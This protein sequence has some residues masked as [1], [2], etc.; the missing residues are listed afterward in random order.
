MDRVN[1]TDAKAHLS[2]LVDRV[3]RGFDGSAL[4][5]RS[6]KCNVTVT[7]TVRSL[8]RIDAHCRGGSARLH[9]RRAT[10]CARARRVASAAQFRG[11]DPIDDLPL[12]AVAVCV[13]STLSAAWRSK[14]DDCEQRHDGK[15]VLVDHSTT[16]SSVGG[17]SQPKLPVAP[18]MSIRTRPGP[19]G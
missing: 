8:A 2:E 16:L 18:K 1:L 14:G 4:N 9:A 7:S 15:D 13:R 5:L 3:R 12:I 11:V 19:G 6:I 10:Q 17:P